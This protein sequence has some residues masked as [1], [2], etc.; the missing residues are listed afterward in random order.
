MNDLDP[1][2]G[3]VDQEEFAIFPKPAATQPKLILHATLADGE[4]AHQK[5]ENAKVPDHTKG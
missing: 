1:P 5:F 3:R 2:K 4:T